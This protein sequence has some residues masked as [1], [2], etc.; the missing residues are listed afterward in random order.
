MVRR[1]RSVLTHG[2]LTHGVLTHGVLTHGVLTHGVEDTQRVD[3]WCGGAAP[4]RW[5]ELF[6]CF[7]L[8][9]ITLS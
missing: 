4:L 7:C 9:E 8:H 2:V 5:A 6:Y 1:R 3:S